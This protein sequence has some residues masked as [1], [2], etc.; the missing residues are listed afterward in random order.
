MARMMVTTQ[1]P[2]SI[3]DIMASSNGKGS[4][5]HE[6]IWTN[7]LSTN[8]ITDSIRKNTITA[9]IN[10]LIDECSQ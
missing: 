1:P 2:P 8:P 5:N 6:V 9:F 7:I 4:M 3:H 10:C